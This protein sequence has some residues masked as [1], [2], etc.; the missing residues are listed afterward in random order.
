MAGALRFTC[1]EVPS[2][3]SCSRCACSVSVSSL[4]VLLLLALLDLVQRRLADVDVAAL[5]QFRHLPVKRTSAS[6]VRMCE[7]STSASVM[8]MMRW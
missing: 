8:M 4:H 3:A 2:S 7:P 1:S 6:S 5:D